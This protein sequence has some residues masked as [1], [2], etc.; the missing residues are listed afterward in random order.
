MCER[1]KPTFGLCVLSAA[2]SRRAACL[3]RVSR[4][5]SSALGRGLCPPQRQHCVARR[6]VSESRGTDQ[7][8]WSPRA[9]R[10][11]D[12]HASR[13]PPSSHPSA[14]R[15]SE[16]LATIRV[17]ACPPAGCCHSDGPLSLGRAA[18]TRITRDQ[19]NHAELFVQSERSLIGDGLHAAAL[20]TAYWRACSH[21]PVPAAMNALRRRSGRRGPSPSGPGHS[22]MARRS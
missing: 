5:S 8:P 13:R 10:G 4:M 14:W 9:G 1:T 11:P 16:C 18:V 21:K 7:Q 2:A 20:V 15:P 17:R 19:R 3:P 6:P 22:C 12:G